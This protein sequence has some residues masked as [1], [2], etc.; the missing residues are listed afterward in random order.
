M[1]GG[2]NFDGTGAFGPWLVTADELPP[3]CSGLRLQTR[4]NGEIVQNA[5]TDDLV[6]NVA[7]LVSTLSMAFTLE[8]G[9]VIVT[10]TPSGVGLAHK[11]P[12]RMKPGDV[13]EVAAGGD[14]GL[15]QPC[16]GPGRNRDR[17][18]GA[19][20]RLTRARSGAQAN[21]SKAAA[22]IGRREMGR[23]P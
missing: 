22:P 8:A 6:F 9:D 15:A 1:N 14:R 19:H 7:T 5:S 11:P 23:Q 20:R 17:E 10:G 16:R 2:K 3:G 13:C 4:L 18:R 21:V 12:L